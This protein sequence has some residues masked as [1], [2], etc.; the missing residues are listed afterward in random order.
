MRLTVS[1]PFVGGMMTTNIQRIRS[2]L[3][4]LVLTGGWVVSAVG[5]GSD[6]FVLVPEMEQPEDLL[7]QSR[8]AREQL[9]DRAE[10]R[11]GLERL[12]A[13]VEGHW[14]QIRRIDLAELSRFHVQQTRGFELPA[15]P[16][17]LTGRPIAADETSGLWYL[18]LRGPRLPARYDIVHRYLYV[19]AGFDPATGELSGLTLTI[20]GWVLE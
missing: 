4:A 20:R 7:F 1:M 17:E 6:D 8:R 15:E 11:R 5:A 14:A 12:E 13:W 18:E 16:G 3:V 2:L 10:A 19:F 9:E